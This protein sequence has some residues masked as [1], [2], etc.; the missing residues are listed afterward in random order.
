MRAQSRQPLRP[1]SAGAATTVHPSSTARSSPRA[2]SSPRST[3]RSI[4]GTAERS[5]SLGGETCARRSRVSGSGTPITLVGGRGSVLARAVEALARFSD[6][7]QWVLVGGLAVFVRLDSITRPTADA[8]TVARSQASLVEVVQ[9]RRRARSRRWRAPDR[10]RRWCRG[11]RRHG[12]GGQPVASRHRTTSL[13]SGPSPRAPSAT[14]FDTHS[15]VCET[16]IDPPAR[17]H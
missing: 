14:T 11:S 9:A 7:G 5:W 1:T 8:D 16:T 4:Q 17:E 13:R 12:L 6:G 15:F 2:P 3:S 10:R